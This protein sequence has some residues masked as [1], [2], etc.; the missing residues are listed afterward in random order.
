MLSW[1]TFKF[2]CRAWIRLSLMEKKLHE[3]FQCLIENVS[4]LEEFYEPH[5]LM[6]NEEVNV[7]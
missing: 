6:R 5:A 2:R 1:L 4:L 3:Y 7:I